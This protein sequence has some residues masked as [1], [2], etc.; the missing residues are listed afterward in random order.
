MARDLS[1]EGA[2]AFDRKKYGEAALTVLNSKGAACCG[3]N[4]GGADSCCG[5]D[6]ITGGLY[7]DAEAASIPD[8]QFYLVL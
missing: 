1:L 5:G 3:G 4:A 6:S 7:D 8:A 2:L